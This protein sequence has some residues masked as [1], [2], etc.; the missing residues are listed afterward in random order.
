MY[1]VAG[2]FHRWNI[3]RNVI[4]NNTISHN[5]AMLSSANR[6]DTNVLWMQIIMIEK[7][8]GG[9]VGEGDGNFATF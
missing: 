4:I 5:H 2:A 9:G 3:I 1:S 7:G 6:T 8:G